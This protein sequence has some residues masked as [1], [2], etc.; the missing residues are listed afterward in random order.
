MKQR[1]KFIDYLRVSA[2]FCVVF[3]HASATLLRQNIN[4]SWQIDNILTSIATIA[5]PIFFMISGAMLLSRNNVDNLSIL[6]RKRL[7]KL[8][9]P[10]VIWSIISILITHYK[11]RTFNFSIVK[12]ILLL[13]SKPGEIAL[14]FMYPF[15]IMYMLAP[16]L[17]LIADNKKLLKYTLLIWLLFVVVL[18]SI[19]LI[20]PASLGINA[21]FIPN[22]NWMILEGYVGF[23]FLGY[24]LYVNNFDIC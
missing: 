13:P 5:V 12:D 2:M 7:P 11:F 22:D 18:P 20:L 21:L 23:F 4:L 17:K 14:W 10:F 1:V 19:P 8:C 16:M 9:I 6:Y 24:Y 15:I 3:L